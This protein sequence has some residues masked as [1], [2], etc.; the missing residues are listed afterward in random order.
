MHIPQDRLAV[1]HQ[2]REGNLFFYL[3]Q[4]PVRRIDDPEEAG[5]FLQDSENY[6]LIEEK[7]RKE[8]SGISP[9]QIL[10]QENPSPFKQNDSERF[11]LI[12]GRSG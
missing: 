9:D 10:L 12:Q 6:L 2:G 11:S 3:D 8:I 7:H 5:R 4:I 1:L